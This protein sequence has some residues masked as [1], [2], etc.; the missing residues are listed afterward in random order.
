[1]SLHS[2]IVSNKYLTD[3]NTLLHDQEL[4]IYFEFSIK[5]FT[6][7]LIINLQQVTPGKLIHYDYKV[8][9]SYQLQL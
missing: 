9:N 5:V 3:T 4:C 2:R 1:M 8:H 6:N 7:K